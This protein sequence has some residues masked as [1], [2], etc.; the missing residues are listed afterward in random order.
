MFCVF[1]NGKKH[2]ASGDGCLLFCYFYVTNHRKQR[3][4]VDLL[5]SIY[6][7]K[8]NKTAGG[9]DNE[10]LCGNTSFL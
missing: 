1:L 9:H 2:Q 10:V 5:R 7:N 8:G 4:S 3:K 6:Y